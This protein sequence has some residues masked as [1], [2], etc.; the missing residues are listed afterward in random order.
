MWIWWIIAILHMY[1]NGKKTL[2]K[3][4]KLTNENKQ[5]GEEA[6]M[7]EGKCEWLLVKETGM[8]AA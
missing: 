2:V 3:W 7:N 8:D 1:S 6:E 4:P 5:V